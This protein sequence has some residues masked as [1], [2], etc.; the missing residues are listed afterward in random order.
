MDHWI[1]KLVEHWAIEKSYLLE[2]KIIWWPPM[3]IIVLARNVLRHI[4]S[5]CNLE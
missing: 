2:N 3:G 5:T 1:E 4:H